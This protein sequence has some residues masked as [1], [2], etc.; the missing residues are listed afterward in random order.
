VVVLDDMIKLLPVLWEVNGGDISV[1][2]HSGWEVS[3]DNVGVR[4]LNS[5]GQQ[6]GGIDSAMGWRYLLPSSL[7]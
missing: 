3:R 4:L 2:G 5:G 7:W 6:L 1:V